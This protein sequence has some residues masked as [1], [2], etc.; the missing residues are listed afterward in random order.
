MCIDLE[1]IRWKPG[2][3]R[4]FPVLEV[5]SGAGE[6]R[7]VPCAAPEGRAEPVGTDGRGRVS[8]GKEEA[9]YNERYSKRM[10]AP[11]DTG[12]VC[13]QTGCISHKIVDRRISG[14]VFFFP[15]NQGKVLRE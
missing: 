4:K 1:K 10:E 3:T 11:S 13:A 7:T 8:A 5:L 15:P 9:F 12:G 2:R 14:S 6:I